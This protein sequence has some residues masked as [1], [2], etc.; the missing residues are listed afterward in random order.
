MFKKSVSISE[1][2]YSQI[3]SAMVDIAENEIRLAEWAETVQTETWSYAKKSDYWIAKRFL[4]D[5]PERKFDAEMFQEFRN[6]LM[7]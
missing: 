3:K 4:S 1:K 6:F 5:L 2:M 7:K